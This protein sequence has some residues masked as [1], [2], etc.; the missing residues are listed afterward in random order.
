MEAAETDDAGPPHPR[1]GTGRLPHRRPDQV[2]RAIAR[3]LA[4]VPADRFPSTAEFTRALDETVP[5]VS[6]VWMDEKTKCPV[7]AAC[8]AVRAVSWSRISPTRITSGS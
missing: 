2:D 1:P 4:R 7:I 5:T 6:R 8:M 3:A